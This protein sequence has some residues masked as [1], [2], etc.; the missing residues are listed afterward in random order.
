ME[1]NA[2]RSIEEEIGLSRTAVSVDRA[3][4]EVSELSVTARLLYGQ[5]HGY[6]CYGFRRCSKDDLLGRKIVLL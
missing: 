2:P 3:K 5:G 6:C 4:V 1:A